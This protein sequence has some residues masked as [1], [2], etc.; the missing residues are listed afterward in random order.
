MHS[1]I[2]K[3]NLILAIIF[4]VFMTTSIAIAAPPKPPPPKD[5]PKPPPSHSS[6]GGYCPGGHPHCV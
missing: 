4:S 6:E 1:H 2:I 3:L 5:K